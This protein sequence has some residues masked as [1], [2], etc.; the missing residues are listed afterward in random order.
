ML[1]V[2]QSSPPDQYEAQ[3]ADRERFAATFAMPAR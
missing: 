1:I 2:H 3:I